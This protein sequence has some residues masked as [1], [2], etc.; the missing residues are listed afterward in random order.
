MTPFGVETIVMPSPF[1]TRGIASTAGIN[2]SPGFRN[3]L[4]LPNDRKT[5]EIFQFDF[6][7]GP[8]IAIF[9]SRITTDIALRLQNIEDMRPKPRT[10][11]LHLAFA[12]HLRIAMRVSISPNGSLIAMIRPSYQ[13]DLTRPG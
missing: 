1:A 11:R 3:P 9:R 12:P 2:P 8:A 7:L 5:V 4:Y 10:R 6:E 13:L